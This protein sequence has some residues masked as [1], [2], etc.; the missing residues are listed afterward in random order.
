[1]V[2]VTA[3]VAQRQEVADDQF[4][5]CGDGL[6]HLLGTGRLEPWVTRHVDWYAPGHLKAMA[7][8][9]RHGFPLFIWENEHVGAKAA[10]HIVRCGAIPVVEGL[11]APNYIF[12]AGTDE[13]FAGNAHDFDKT[14][15]E[16]RNFAGAIEQGIEMAENLADIRAP[17]QTLVKFDACQPAGLE[18]FAVE[19]RER[20]W[21]KAFRRRSIL[22]DHDG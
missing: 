17:C 3:D 4:R 15:L 7:A 18:R 5:G 12:R 22:I 6:A 10:I 14:I 21:W 16:A 11:I 20:T 13:G 1:M 19:T 8:V 2:K 9:V